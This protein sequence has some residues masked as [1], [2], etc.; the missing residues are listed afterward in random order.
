MY[1]YLSGSEWSR[2]DLHI[3]TPETARQDNFTGLNPEEK[4][5]NF[6]KSI[7]EYNE[8]ASNKITVIGITDYVSI[9]NYIK[10]IN[11]RDKLPESIKLIL[12]NVEIRMTPRS[13]IHGINIHFIFNPSIVYGLNDRFFSRLK[14]VGKKR[15]Y[16]GTRQELIELGKSDDKTIPDDKAYKIGNEAFLPSFENIKELFLSDTDLRD[17]TIILV[18]NNSTDG[19]TGA[20]KTH[21]SFS[22]DNDDSFRKMRET[23]YHFA[24]GIL[25]S[26]DND[27]KYFLGEKKG[28]EDI[29][30]RLGALKPCLHGSDAHDNKKIFEPN[31]KRY[32]WIKSNPTF[33]GLK[34]VIWE[35]KERVQIG[36]SIPTQKEKYNIIEKV[37]FI[38]K[39][40]TKKFSDDWIYLNSNLNAIIG[41]KSSGKSLL[42][43]LIAKTTQS[44]GNFQDD[45]K[46][47]L[48][49]LNLDDFQV[50]WSNGQI[51]NYKS[52]EKKGILTYIP[53]FYLNELVEE[54]KK[55][56]E[57]NGLI[58]NTLQSDDDL[59]IKYSDFEKEKK[60]IEKKKNLLK[61]E[62]VNK[63][64]EKAQIKEQML[65]YQEEKILE[66]S[67]REKKVEIDK[68]K[69]DYGINDE[70]LK[71]EEKLKEKLKEI[72][73]FRDKDIIDSM[74]VNIN[75]KFRESFSNFQNDFLYFNNPDFVTIL[76]QEIKNEGEKILKNLKKDIENLNIKFNEDI[77]QIEIKINEKEKL[78]NQKKDEIIEKLKPVSLRMENQKMLVEKERILKQETDKLSTIKKLNEKFS[79]IEEEISQNLKKVSEI[80]KQE[81]EIYEK[82]QNEIRELNQKVFTDDLNVNLKLVFDNE[83]YSKDIE[84]ILNM[85]NRQDDLELYKY[86]SEKEKIEFENFND[87]IFQHYKNLIL[88]DNKKIKLK[89]NREKK[90]LIELVLKNYIRKNYDIIKNKDSLSTMS[91]GKRGLILLQLFLSISTKDYPIL[92]DQPEDNLDNR[93]VYNELK[94]IISKKKIKRQIIITTHNANL[95]VSADAEEVIVANQ[96]GENSGKENKEF[97]FEYVTGALENSYIDE[98]QKGILYKKGI[99]EHVCEILE[100]G[101][102]AFK[103][104]RK[105]YQIK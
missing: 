6:Y 64:D 96:E 82:I 100:G 72:E 87:M 65:E 36:E 7:S 95:V 30:E 88:L 40:N 29:E 23:I 37:R 50:Q 54:K 97:Q 3:H 67:V 42:L 43:Y 21:K 10:V 48:N 77:K 61:L 92:V 19:V 11:E 55:E 78:R 93:T 31:E 71:E 73:A 80:L 13:K 66:A 91:P 103:K 34:Q 14:F 32:C 33:N 9:E 84:N 89:K 58:K 47:D 53:Q 52:N 20:D 8:K 85:N 81:K 1:K 94:E 44:N 83:S 45:N 56:S 49:E 2:W 86:L 15:E 68:I 12:P 90:E 38:P 18:S 51:D 63:L 5:K 102:E 69:K 79:S 75:F 70:Q 4:W 98:S 41:G 59:K 22:E 62:I 26:T 39:E 16:S 24:D 99:K 28:D 35:P 101:E 60:E 104:R 46:Y 74:K 76:D 57:L 17:N 25:S 27:I 105:K